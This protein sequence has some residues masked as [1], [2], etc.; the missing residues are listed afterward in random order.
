MK[1]V[2]FGNGEAAILCLW[3]LL[4]RRSGKVRVIAPPGAK[5]QPWHLSLEEECIKTSV[6]YSKPK[7]VNSSESIALLSA[8]NP[9]I[10]FSVY[11]TQILGGK[12]L[13]LSQYAINFHPSLLPEY[14]GTAPLIWTIVNGEHKTGITAH[15]MTLRVDA[16]KIY[17]RREIEISSE[18]TGY[19]LHRKASITCAQVFDEVFSLFLD[20]KLHGYDMEGKGSYYSSKTPG[21]NRLDPKEQTVKQVCNIVRALVKPLPGAYYIETDNK[22]S[23]DKVTV[24]NTENVEESKRG[25]L[26]REATNLYLQCRDGVVRLDD[27]SISEVNNENPVL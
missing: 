8:F 26:F 2:L 12:L 6:P 27:Y 22:Y 15:Q 23:I 10:M 11:Y 1:V 3:K 4:R 21:V 16:G 13:R 7:E 19:T 9:D 5:H 20:G 24:V 17:M 25:E 18:D 14:R